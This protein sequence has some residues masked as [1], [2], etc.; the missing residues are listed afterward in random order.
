MS[1]KSEPTPLISIPSSAPGVAEK[2]PRRLP[3]QVVAWL[4][5]LAAFGLFCLLI[6]TAF[7]LISDYLSQSTEYKA[8]QVRVAL[9]RD[10]NVFVQ[11]RGQSKEILVSEIEN[12]NEGDEIRTGKDSDAVLVLFD[13][14]RLDLTP[15]SRVRLE[16]SRVEIRNFR[17]TEKQV[18]V[19]VQ[20][21]L[22]WFTVQPF[23]TGRD[24]SKAS[25]R[26]FLPQEGAA[27][28]PTEMWFNDP[29]TG[30]YSDGRYGLG[31]NRAQEKESG[32]RAWFTNKARKPI[33]VRSPG[34]VVSVG[35]GQRVA[36]EGGV[37]G[38]PMLPG[39]LQTQLVFNG[40]FLNGWDYWQPYSDQGS[41]K[42]PIDGLV[43]FDAELI[44]D[45]AQPR[46]RI[47]RL[48]PRGEGNFAETSML[49]DINRDVSDYEELDFR[50]K[51]KLVSQSLAGGGYLGSEYPLFIK[52]AYLDKN[53]ERQEFFRGFYSKPSDI[54][55]TD[56]DRVGISQKFTQ[57]EW[58]DWHFNLM[59]LR[60][61]PT[62]ILRVTIG[63]SGH[64]YDSYFTDVSLIAR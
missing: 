13:G 34:K 54:R 37:P 41:D 27:S 9:G 1:V 15:E 21:G 29:L 56:Q 19:G 33:D 10:V 38:V 8:G 28:G 18:A 51:F 59:E 55:T 30:N 46:A 45:G 43:Q 14:S 6:F 64:L 36:F 2:K 40:S 47:M 63:S 5:L 48:D 7:N 22:V 31:V 58:Q 62:R 53:N 12:V 20:N 42:G 26:A 11:H 24:Y 52:I 60:N 17:R 39:E 50:L 25:F 49:Q 35:P 44:D 16:R 32:L 23:V 61:K 3:P 4:V 57:G